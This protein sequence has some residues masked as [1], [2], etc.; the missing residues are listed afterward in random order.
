MTYRPAL[1]KLGQTPATYEHKHGET[2]HALP[3]ARKVAASFVRGGI[4]GLFMPAVEGI[5]ELCYGRCS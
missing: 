3:L 1:P 4:S 5:T 2:P